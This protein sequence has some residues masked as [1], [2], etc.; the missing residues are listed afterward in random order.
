MRGLEILLGLS[1]VHSANSDVSR[2][3]KRDVGVSLAEGSSCLM[4]M[5]NAW[6]FWDGQPVPAP[7]PFSH[8]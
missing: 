3:T 6:I 5:K 1:G 7:R 2:Y 8:C 4:G